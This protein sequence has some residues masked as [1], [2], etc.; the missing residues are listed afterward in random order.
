MKKPKLAAPVVELLKLA[1]ECRKKTSLSLARIA[2]LAGDNSK[3]FSNLEK[4]GN[5]TMT[6]YQAM[7]DTMARLN[8]EAK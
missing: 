8:K 5:C 4:G 6:K 3:F 1:D 7:K 2:V